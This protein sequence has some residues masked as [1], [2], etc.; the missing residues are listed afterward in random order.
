[1]ITVALFKRLGGDVHTRVQVLERRLEPKLETLA[2]P[3]QEARPVLD[4]LE[5][6]MPKKDRKGI[7]AEL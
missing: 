7:V 2:A 3:C 5:L 6:T 4:Q 1:L